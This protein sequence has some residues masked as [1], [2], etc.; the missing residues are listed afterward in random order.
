MPEAQLAS[1]RGEFVLGGCLVGDIDP[2]CCCLRCGIRFDFVR[3][4]LARGEV[5]QRGWVED[6]GGPKQFEDEG[7]A[8]AA[9]SSR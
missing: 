6:D 2:R 7:T 3:P 9:T 1:D 5:A 4:E 8:S